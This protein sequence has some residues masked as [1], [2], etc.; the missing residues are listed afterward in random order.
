MGVE[1]CLCRLKSAGNGRYGLDVVANA[2]V[3]VADIGHA[4]WMSTSRRILHGID[5]RLSV[6]VRRDDED[7]EEWSKEDD[8]RSALPR[9]SSNAT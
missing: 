2:A 7:E 6:D 3:P 9:C 5:H 8:R 1:L 4:I